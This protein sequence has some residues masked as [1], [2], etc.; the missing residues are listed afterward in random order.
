LAGKLAAAVINAAP[1]F[2]TAVSEA[3]EAISDTYGVEVCPV[4]IGQRV[5]FARSLVTG[6]TAGEIEPDGK[7]AAEVTALWQRVVNV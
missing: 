4:V 2:G 1:A 3:A 7:A 6:Q 5:A